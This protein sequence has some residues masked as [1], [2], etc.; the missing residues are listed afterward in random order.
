VTA[1]PVLA[2]RVMKARRESE[3][4]ACCDLVRIGQMIARC[5]GGLWM[6]AS[7]FIGH[8]H[9]LGT[10]GNPCTTHSKP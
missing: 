5:P 6:H 3:C 8:R 2:D 1:I 4:P 9:E 10:E 7:C